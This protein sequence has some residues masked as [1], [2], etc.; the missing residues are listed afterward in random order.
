MFFCFLFFFALL[1]NNVNSNFIF[2][3]SEMYVS[4][5]LCVFN[6]LSVMEATRISK[7]N[8]LLEKARYARN[9]FYSEISW[10]FFL[11]KIHK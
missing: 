1:F 4:E 3:R 10:N 2:V 7:L 9:V 8:D 6:F 5:K 11:S